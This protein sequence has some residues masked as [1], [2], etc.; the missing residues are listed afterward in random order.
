M[1]LEANSSTAPD[2]FNVEARQGLKAEHLLLSELLSEARKPFTSA[3]PFEWMD[4]SMTRTNAWKKIEAIEERGKLFEAVLQR[5]IHAG[6]I[7]DQLK[8]E[9][10]QGLREAT[11]DREWDFRWR[12]AS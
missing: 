2:D 9:T 12:V 4:F 3:N 7:I 10:N 11:G 8:A 6:E 5:L 1:K